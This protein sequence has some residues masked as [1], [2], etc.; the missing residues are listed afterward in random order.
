MTVHAGHGSAAR[1]GGFTLLELVIAMGLLAA[2]LTMLVQL[3]GGGASLF[4]SGERG[5]E[6]A[7]RALTASRAAEGALQS[8]AGPRVDALAGEAAVDARLIVHRVVAGVATPVG[9]PP[10]RLPVLRSTARLAPADEERLLEGALRELVADEL[11][12]DVSRV[13]PDG[14]PDAIA[15][16]DELRAAWPL[17]GRG[18]LLMAAW[19][20][21]DTG[22]Y[23]AL[24]VGERLADADLLA[25]GERRLVDYADLDDL[26]L[27]A[28]TLRARTRV[29]ATGLLH[30]DL[31]LWSQFT[32]DWDAGSGQGPLQ[33]WDSA[34]AGLLGESDDRR[35]AFLLDVGPQSLRDPRDDVWPRWIRVTIVV[36]GPPDAAP[37]AY[38]AQSLSTDAQRMV[39]TTVERLP[40]PT[41]TRF[42]KVG[43]EWVRYAN[44]AGTTLDGLRRGE[45][46]TTALDHPA[47]TPV[48]AGRTVQL[49]VPIP[50]G[51][52]ADD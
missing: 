10:P 38:L 6:L 35:D 30:F 40:P 29:V 46:G 2:F 45:R 18:E 22:V 28:G 12:L 3:V 42:L 1:E 4:D 52:D 23:L 15:R 14:D 50:H 7:D 33:V 16:L 49:C 9:P 13:G 19:P 20:V 43:A 17:R 44:E 39:V 27:D 32:T 25:E 8:T 36:A 21:D 11:R 31:E 37:E 26:A 5:Q 48:R 47:G 41:E 24:H 51:R 34:R